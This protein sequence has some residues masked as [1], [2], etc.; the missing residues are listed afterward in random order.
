MSQ[1]VV[2]HLSNPTDDEIERGVDVLCAAFATSPDTFGASITGG[3]MDLHR[4]LHRAAIRAG[5]IG[6]EV[7]VAGFGPTDISAVAVWFGPGADYLASEEQR[8]AGWNEVHSQFTP[9]LKKWWS[10]YFLPRYVVWNESCLGKDTKLKS[11]HLHLL[12]TSPDHHRKGL[13]AA[14]ITAVEAKAKNDG[15]IMCLE[16]TNDKN[17]SFYKRVGFAMRGDISIVGSGGEITMTCL[18]KP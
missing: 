10:D 1:V 8:Q 18:S 4:P 16:T 13:A 9:E 6:G 15:V 7:W 5:V 17:V 2:R 3:N 12:G 14:L 11:W